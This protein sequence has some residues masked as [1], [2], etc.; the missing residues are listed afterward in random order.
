MIGV[1][2]LS[3]KDQAGECGKWAGFML[4]ILKI[5]LVSRNSWIKYGFIW[6][7]I[8]KF[9]SNISIWRLNSLIQNEDVQKSKSLFYQANTLHLIYLNLLDCR[10]VIFR[11]ILATKFVIKQGNGIMWQIVI[12]KEKNSAI[13][14]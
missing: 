10:F 13:K 14:W 4:L 9:H 8:F 5:S 12:S 7:W 1:V 2:L 3:K 6:I 11:S